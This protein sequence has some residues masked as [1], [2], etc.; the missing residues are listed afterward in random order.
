ML[1]LD[2]LAPCAHDHS[3]HAQYCHLTTSWRIVSL[4]SVLYSTVMGTCILL[5]I[6]PGNTVSLRTQ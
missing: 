4:L 2:V 5:S 1:T 6:L 3:D